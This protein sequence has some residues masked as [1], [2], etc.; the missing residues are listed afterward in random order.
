MERWFG[1]E[2]RWIGGGSY[3]ADCGT[4][5]NRDIQSIVIVDW[6]HVVLFSGMNE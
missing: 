1:R 2:Y 5:G 3:S 6:G 4:G